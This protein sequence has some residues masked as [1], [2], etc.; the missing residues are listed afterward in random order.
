ML[1]AL[2]VSIALGALAGATE[3]FDRNLAYTS[4]FTNAIHVRVLSA[5]F[6]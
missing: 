3:L 4:P 6:V 1:S 2:L 5:C